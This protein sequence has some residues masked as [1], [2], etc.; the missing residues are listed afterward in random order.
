MSSRHARFS[1]LMPSFWASAGHELDGAVVRITAPLKLLF[2]GAL[3]GSTA[4]SYVALIIKSCRGR[5]VRGVTP[6]KIGMAIVCKLWRGERENT[7][8]I[9]HFQS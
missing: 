7:Q 3:S 5:G 6:T 4:W 8:R 2:N 9:R 1:R